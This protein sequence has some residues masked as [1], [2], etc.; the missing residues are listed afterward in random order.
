MHV[1]GKP[2][3]DADCKTWQLRLDEF[4]PLF[5]KVKGF[6]ISGEPHHYRKPQDQQ[7]HERHEQEKGDGGKPC[8]GCGQER[9]HGIALRCQRDARNVQR[10]GKAPFFDGITPY[11]MR[12]RQS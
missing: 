10:Q 1:R 5:H 4:P 2:L 12:Q 7:P 11:W 8:G 9:F 3:L 6:V